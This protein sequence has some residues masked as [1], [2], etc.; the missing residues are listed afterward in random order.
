[1]SRSAFF[2][3]KK[4]RKEK[5]RDR[6]WSKMAQDLESY[7]GGMRVSTGRRCFTTNLIPLID[8]YKE[9]IM[10]IF[11]YDIYHRELS[12]RTLGHSRRLII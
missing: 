5:S 3:E 1:M 7:E 2:L 11:G 8:Q 12:R 10:R 9:R 6:I 4:R